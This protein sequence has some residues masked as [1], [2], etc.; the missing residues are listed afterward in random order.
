MSF[1]HHQQTT[2]TECK[3]LTQTDNDTTSNEDTNISTGRKRLHDR[4]N[5]YQNRS[6]CDAHA[7]SSPVSQG[8]SEEKPSYNGT[9]RV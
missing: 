2:L 8:A 7:S 5:Y 9:D 3:T 6:H 4:R 1:P